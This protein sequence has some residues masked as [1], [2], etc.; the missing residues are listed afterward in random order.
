MC[1]MTTKYIQYLANS[2]RLQTEC[3][4][5]SVNLCIE[6]WSPN[7]KD[8]DFEVVT[9]IKLDLNMLAR[10]HALPCLAIDLKYTS[11]Y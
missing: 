2:I 5:E 8:W 11:N 10:P 4:L 7:S 9:Y 6:I 3:H 1:H